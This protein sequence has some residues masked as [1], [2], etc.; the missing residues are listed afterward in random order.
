MVDR[1]APVLPQVVCLGPDEFD[2]LWSPDVE[3]V[4]GYVF[5]DSAVH[6]VGRFEFL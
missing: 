2:E 4:V 5:A 3:V 6:S 1:F